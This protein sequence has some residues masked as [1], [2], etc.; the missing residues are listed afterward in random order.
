MSCDRCAWHK[1]NAG[2][3]HNL[4]LPIRETRGLTFDVRGGPLAGRPLDGV[5]R[6][7]TLGEA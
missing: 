6:R 2:H 3:G 4:A 5:V 7:R 1:L